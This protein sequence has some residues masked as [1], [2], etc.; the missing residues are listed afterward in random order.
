M[1]YITAIYD[2]K[3]CGKRFEKETSLQEGIV[4]YIELWIDPAYQIYSHK[5]EDCNKNDW[6]DVGIG[7]LVGTKL[8]RKE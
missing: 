6:S 7:I 4:P 1:K 3:R 5:C 2:C 8:I